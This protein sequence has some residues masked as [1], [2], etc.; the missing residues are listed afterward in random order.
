MSRTRRSRSLWYLAIPAGALGVGVVVL[1]ALRPALP[2][3][4]GV[5]RAAALLGYGGVFVAVLSSA[6]MSDLVRFFGRSF[7][8]VHHVITLAA[9]AL[10]TAH[11][12]TYALLTRDAGVF[13]PEVGSW[14]AFWTHAGR[15]A[16]YLLILA[17]VVAFRRASVGKRWRVVHWLTYLA[18]GM[19]TVHA[20]RLG[21]DTSYLATRVLALAMLAAVG[22]AFVLKRVRTRRPPPRRRA[23]A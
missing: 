9:L 13:V 18:F 15:P 12:L 10:L 22:A 1:L 5:L 4:Y 7:T 21:T 6:Y 23:A 2:W 8:A 11:P 19:A 14:S 20:L 3:G 17:A 16:W